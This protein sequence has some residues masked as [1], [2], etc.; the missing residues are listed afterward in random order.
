MQGEDFAPAHL[1]ATDDFTASMVVTQSIGYYIYQ[2][3]STRL[4][5]SLAI[6][7]EDHGLQRLFDGSQ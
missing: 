7:W 5:G 1:R 6:G 4:H 2:T 3:A